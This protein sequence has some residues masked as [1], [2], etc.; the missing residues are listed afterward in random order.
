MQPIKN[1]VSGS[2]V[3]AS[4]C[5]TQRIGV[6]TDVSTEN[7]EGGREPMCVETCWDKVLGEVVCAAASKDKV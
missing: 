1:S 5:T 7:E 6:W 2:C 4:C 3:A